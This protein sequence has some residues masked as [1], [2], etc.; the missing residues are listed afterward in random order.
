MS[1]SRVLT[2]AACDV[3]PAPPSATIAS[4]RPTS[5]VR[6][7]CH[8][9]LDGDGKCFCCCVLPQLCLREVIADEPDPGPAPGKLAR[10]RMS[11]AL[12]PY[13]LCYASP[14]P[15]NSNNNPVA[16]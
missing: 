6:G 5:N 8:K 16:H 12:L 13:R 14:V 10:H 2:S 3:D 11:A 15:Y 1:S 9:N 4:F 7:V